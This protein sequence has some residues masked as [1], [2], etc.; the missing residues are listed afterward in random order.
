M[1]LLHGGR[2]NQIAQQYQIPI[3]DWLD[4]STGISPLNYPIPDIAPQLWQQ[5]PQENPALLNAAKQYYRC[6]QLLVTN[7]SQSII[8][9]L[10]KLWHAHAPLSKTVYLPLRGYKEHAH[11]WQ[12]A[13][14]QLSF[15]QD[16][17]PPINTLEAN[18]VLVVINPNNPT[19]KLFSQSELKKYQTQ[20]TI[21][22]GLLVVDEAFMDVVPTNYSMSSLVNND[23]ILVLRSFGKFFGLAGI[24]IGFLIAND[25]WS[26][27]FTSELG[28]WQVNG[29]AL[30]IAEHALLDTIWQTQQRHHLQQLRQQ[31]ETLLW[32]VFGKELI[33][34]IHGT[35]LFLTVNFHQQ[36]TANELYHL[37]CERGVYCRLTDEQDTLRFGIATQEQQKRLGDV[38]AALKRNF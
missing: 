19:G 16:E 21:L 37:L 32:D 7:G 26:Q 12:V 24:R 36:H 6:K 18:S 17:L 10:P 15:Y 11:A 1:T 4:L 33:S 2:L 22:N 31:Q 5:L 29:P 9:I 28:P 35:D 30:L 8:K 23:N 34:K 13:G 20:L 27:I 25:Y 38:L 3:N 14:Y